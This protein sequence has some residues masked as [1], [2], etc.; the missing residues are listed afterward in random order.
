M[1]L[2]GSVEVTIDGELVST[3]GPG[4]IVGEVA[5]VVDVPADGRLFRT[6]SEA[7]LAVIARQEFEQVLREAPVATRLYG[8]SPPDC[9]RWPRQGRLVMDQTWWMPQPWPLTARTDE[10][11][12][13]ARR[14]ADPGVGGTVLTGPAGVGKSRLAE[15]VME[16]IGGPAA[17]RS[18]TR[19]PVGTARR[20]RPPAPCRSGVIRPG[21]RSCGPS[22]SIRG[23]LRSGCSPT[24]AD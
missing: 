2:D 1:V 4:E 10:I 18:G 9:S 15:A 21:V 23:G 6:T 14:H 8:P 3:L 13:L 11:R 22:C 12:R 7:E 17:G 16:A 19:P 5:M 24:G 20:P